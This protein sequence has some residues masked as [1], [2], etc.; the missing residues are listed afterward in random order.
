MSLILRCLCDIQRAQ[1]PKYWVLCAYVQCGIRVELR[2]RSSIN[3]SYSRG[4]NKERREGTQ[5]R[6]LKKPHVRG[7]RGNVCISFCGE[8]GG[9]KGQGQV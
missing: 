9:R 3:G 6:T 5:G 4:L 1:I 2:D 7:C 8:N